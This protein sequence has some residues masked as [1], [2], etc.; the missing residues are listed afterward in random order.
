MN[1]L[2]TFIYWLLLILLVVMF[3]AYDYFKNFPVLFGYFICLLIIIILMD[4]KNKK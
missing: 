3:I 1:K 4:K 2:I